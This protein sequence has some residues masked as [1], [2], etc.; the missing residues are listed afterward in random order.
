MNLIGTVTLE[1]ERLI[2]RKTIESDAETMFYNWA[3]D[4]RVTKYLTW[5][6]YESVEQLRTSYHQ[7]LY[8]I[9]KE[10]YCKDC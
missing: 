7:Y 4:S 10:D 2:L 6:L 1:T 9:L 5:Y 8:A 3:N